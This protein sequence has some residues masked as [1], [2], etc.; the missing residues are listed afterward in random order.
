MK[1]Y[2]YIIILVIALL[3]GI[4]SNCQN[5]FNNSKYAALVNNVSD[6][7]V[8]PIGTA[9]IPSISR[10]TGERYYRVYDIASYERKSFCWIVRTTDGQLIEFSSPGFIIIDN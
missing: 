3:V 1:S 4:L 2:T 8:Y 5:K 9:Y 10:M 6:V 7:Q